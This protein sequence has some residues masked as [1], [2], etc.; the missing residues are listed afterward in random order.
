MDNQK[1]VLIVGAGPTG[2]TAAVELARRGIIP[3]VIDKKTSASTLSRA[4]GIIPDSLKI[5]EASGMTEKLLSAGIKIYNGH[6]H[7]D[8]KEVLELQFQGVA[9][10]YDFLLSLPQDQ[11]ESILSQTL[12]SLGGQ[13]TYGQELTD[14]KEVNGKIQATLNNKNIIEADYLIG[15]DGIRSNVRKCINIDYPG[16]DLEEIW[17]I[18]DIDAINWPFDKSV[19]IYRHNDNANV[20]FIIPIAK[21]R[22]RIVS[23]TADALKTLPV[24][25]DV[26]QTH[27]QGTFNISV[28]Q[29]ESYQKGNIF[30]AGDAAHCHSPVGGRG[31]NLGIADAAKLAELIAENNTENYTKERH[32]AGKAIVQASEKARLLM[33][34]PNKSFMLKT[35]I[36]VASMISPIKKS[37]AKAMLGV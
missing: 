16:I 15:A 20:T 28:R 23:N 19:S 25:I 2:L 24:P 33:T 32:D 7:F 1:R 26:T 17:S 8:T 4:V 3:T 13:V 27:R 34:N 14:L 22:Y 9:H 30:L 35:V 21:N 31:M 11:T 5:F 18:A 36:K 10:P 6:L 12:A 29:A 37:A